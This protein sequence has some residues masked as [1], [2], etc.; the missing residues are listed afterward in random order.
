METR[1][2]MNRIA[3]LSVDFVERT[4]DRQQKILDFHQPEQLK[5]VLDLTIP[6]RPLDLEQLLSD[7][8]DALKY[9]V[10]TGKFFKLFFVYMYVFRKSEMAGD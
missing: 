1:E 3:E 8:K 9:Q 7:C 4:F 2:F 10:K 5:E 6:Q